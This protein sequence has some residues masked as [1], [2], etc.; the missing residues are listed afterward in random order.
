MV[1]YI[2]IFLYLIAMIKEAKK[3]GVKEV[4]VH[5]L[6]DGR[7]VLET[8]ALQYVDQLKKYS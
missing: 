7:D 5:A 1:M 3:E 6:L 2:P 4:R 8:S